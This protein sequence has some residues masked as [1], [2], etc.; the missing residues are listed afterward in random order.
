M[1]KLLAIMNAKP[2]V[3]AD[4]VLGSMR[5]E[6]NEAWKDKFKLYFENYH[7]ERSESHR[8][9]ADGVRVKNVPRIHIVGFV[10]EIQFFLKDLRCEPEQF[11]QQDHLHINVQRHCMGRRMELKKM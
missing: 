5:D 2:Y 11:Q 8:W 7:F 1:T 9:K 6:P 3:F 4:S 10:K